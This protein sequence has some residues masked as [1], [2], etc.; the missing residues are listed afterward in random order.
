MNYTIIV[1]GFRKKSARVVVARQLAR[2][3]GITLHEALAKTEHLPITL[4]RSIGLEAV[5][6]MID[7]YGRLGIDIQAI[8]SIPRIMAGNENEVPLIPAITTRYRRESLQGE[9]PDHSGGDI[10]H[11]ICPQ[12]QPSPMPPSQRSS[13][14]VRNG[15]ILG[16]SIVLAVV[17]LYGLYLILRFSAPTGALIKKSETGLHDASSRTKKNTVNRSG[18]AAGRIVTPGARERA[19]SLV[20]SAKAFGSDPESAIR[21]YT[22]AIAFNKNNFNAWFGL[23][24]A[25]ER[26]GRTSDAETTRQRMRKIFGERGISIENKIQ[27]FGELAEMRNENGTLMIEYRTRSPL[28]RGNILHETFLIYRAVRNDCECS[29]IS[30]FAT[31]DGSS[32]FEVHLRTNKEIVSVTEFAQKATISF[33]NSPEGKKAARLA[34]EKP[35]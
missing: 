18:M 20:D 27:P 22:M 6:P 28:V 9:T 14:S 4:F 21:F 17:V 32:G 2:E 33:F 5:G 1:K 26:S 23:L 12:D 7:R 10:H 3:A 24:D 25:Y 31:R 11:I 29:T 30:L 13:M 34:D 15:M 8:E 16:G 35:Q 19:R